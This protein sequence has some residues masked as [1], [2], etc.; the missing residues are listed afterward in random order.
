[1]EACNGALPP[2][3]ERNYPVLFE[4]LKAMATCV[5]A[6]HDAAGD[7]T[8][9]VMKRD[10]SALREAV[11]WHFEEHQDAVLEEVKRLKRRI[12]SSS[13][14]FI[15]LCTHGQAPVKLIPIIAQQALGMIT[16]CDLPNLQEH[17]TRIVT[18][19]LELMDLFA[20]NK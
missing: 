6:H 13:S 3:G 19:T 7:I 2:A 8:R 11:P 16:Q 1:M 9:L 15:A 20:D 12:T 14:T 5:G 4:G 17:F 10:H 18:G